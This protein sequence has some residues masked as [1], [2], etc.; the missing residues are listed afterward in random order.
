MRNIYLEIQRVKRIFRLSI[1]IIGGM[2]SQNILNLVDIFFVK[3]L[4]DAALAASG[5]GGFLSFAAIAFVLGL[6]TG[7][8]ALSSRIKGAGRMQ[9]AAVP[10]NCGLFLAVILGVAISA[11]VYFSCPYFY[12]YI[13]NDGAV[14]VPGVP[15]L[16]IRVLGGIFVGINFV[17]RGY[18]NAID[19]PQVYLATLLVMHMTNIVLN[20]LLIFGNGGFPKLGLVG[21]AWGTTLSLALGSAIYGVSALKMAKNQGFLRILPQR[22]DFKKMLK[23][24]APAGLQQVFF[25]AGLVAFYQVVGGISTSALAAANILTN[26]M[27]FAVLPEMGFGLA[28]TTLVG[29]SLGAADPS[30]AKAWAWD[31][32]KIG[33]MAAFL[34]GCPMWLCPEWLLQPFA[35]DLQT[36]SL[37]LEPL[38]ITGL[39]ICFDAVG[40]VL[41][42][43]LLGAGAS[44]F[45]MG[46]SLTIQWLVFIPL[47]YLSVSWWHFG[48]LEVWLMQA[49]YRLL[50]GIIFAIAWQRN[51]WSKISI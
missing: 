18:W 13:N 26:I 46:V 45:V 42:Y 39:I 44:T 6:S 2:V 33:F 51:R 22:S 29:Q 14:V 32:C 30:G 20:Y 10:L 1:P 17:F 16:Q 24:S 43:A 38:R 11:V 3:S 21:A 25:A 28:T 12:P 49:I 34:I 40:V 27:L 48:L 50:Q 47:A 7:V 8:Q 15:Y 4:G 37:A 5:L 19:R 31:V 41:M 23:I 9:E 36:L 35:P